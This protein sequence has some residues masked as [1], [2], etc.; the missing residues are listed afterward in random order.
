[1]IRTLTKYIDFSHANAYD[2]LIRP[3]Q[4]V[5]NAITQGEQDAKKITSLLLRGSVESV[6]ETMQPFVSESIFFEAFND[7]LSR[8]GVSKTG[9]RVFDPDESVGDKIY[10]SMLHIAQTQIPGSGHNC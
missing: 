1:M 7:I 8:G 2:T 10:K 6:S 3:V 4:T 5:L 9:K